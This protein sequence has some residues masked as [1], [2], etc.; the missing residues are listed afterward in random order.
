MKFKTWQRKLFKWK[1]H[2]V[3]Y[4]IA[5][6]GIMQHIVYIFVKISA[7]PYVIYRNIY[8]TYCEK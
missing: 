2:L 6:V 5:A 7:L 3:V 1:V 4:R 8:K